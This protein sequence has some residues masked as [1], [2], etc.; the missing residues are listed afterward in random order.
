M[1]K[2]LAR[3]R[4]LRLFF[5]R[6]PVIYR[7]LCFFFKCTSTLLWHDDI[8]GWNFNIDAIQFFALFDMATDPWQLHN[9]YRT[10]PRGLQSELHAML[11]RANHCRGQEEGAGSP[12]SPHFP[13][14]LPCP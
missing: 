9:I 11:A 12:P 3:A 1:S 8:E 7:F 13:G 14:A 6:T 5:L 4:L 10:S 2:L